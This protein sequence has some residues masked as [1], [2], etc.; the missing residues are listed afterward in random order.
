[1]TAAQCSISHGYFEPTVAEAIAIVH[2]LR[3]CMEV[4]LLSICLEGD[5]KNV[6]DAMNYGEANW[7]KIGHLVE[8]AKILLNTFTHFEVNFVGGEANFA[9][10]AFSKL[11]ARPFFFLNE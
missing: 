10:H 6:V 5:A 9:A 4:G 7:S 2:A 3:F 1:V 11:A 8:D